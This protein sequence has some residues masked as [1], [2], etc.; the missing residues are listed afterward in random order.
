MKLLENE[1]LKTYLIL[2][3]GIVTWNINLKSTKKDKM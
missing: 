2:C 1:M 3:G